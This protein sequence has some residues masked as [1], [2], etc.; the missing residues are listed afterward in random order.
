MQ[1]YDITIDFGAD[2]SFTYPVAA[3][4]THQAIAEAQGWL[5]AQFVELGCE[6]LRPTG[7]VLTADKTLA[8]ALEAGAQR[9]REMPEW[10]E[11]YARAT[12]LALNRAVVRINVADRTVGY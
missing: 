8:I 11:Q 1:Q 12:A 5:D 10:A 6:P 3:E 2:E 7:K 4:P 9:F